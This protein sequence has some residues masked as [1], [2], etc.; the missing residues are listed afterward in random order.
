MLLALIYLL[1][2]RALRLAAGSASEL[3]ND[4]E[5]VVLRQQLA[6]SSARREGRA[7]AVETGC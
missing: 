6:V 1:L 5:T 2:R 7:S 4:I 3:H